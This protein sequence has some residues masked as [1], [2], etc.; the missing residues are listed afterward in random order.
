MLRFFTFIV[1][2]QCTFIG[3]AYAYFDPGI[4][5][6]LYQVGYGLITAT[7]V[8]FISGPKR[9]WAYCKSFFHKVPDK[10]PEEQDKE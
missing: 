9:V 2:I 8:L 5:A 4:A 6:F 10:V 3:N 7:L 1:L